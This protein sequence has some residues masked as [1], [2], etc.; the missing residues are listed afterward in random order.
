M[1]LSNYYCRLIPAYAQIAEPL[2][3]LLRKTSKSFQWTT[4][5]ETSFNTL[6]SKLTTSPVLAFPG[7]TDPVLVATDAS[8]T[9]IG[10]VLSQVQD[11][12]EQVIAYW[13]RQ[14]HKAEHNYST[15]ER[16]VLTVV[17]AVK[18]LYPYLYG[19]PFKLITD[20]NP[21]TSLKGIK[22]TGR[23]LTRWLLFLQQFTFTVECKKGTSHSNADTLSRRPPD[24][25]MVAAV[26]TYTFLADP[27]VLIQAQAADLNLLILNSELHRAQPHSPRTLSSRPQKVFFERW[28]PLP[29]VQGVDYTA[30]TY[31][32]SNSRKPQEYSILQEV[33]D[34]LGHFGAKKTFDRVKSRF[35]WPGY[36][37][38]VE[39]WVKQCEQCQKRNP[40]Q[41][42]PIAPLGTIKTT[43]PFERL[44]WDIMG[45]LP[46]STKGNK[47]ILVIT[48]L[49]PNG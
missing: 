33:Y 5:C 18:E 41:P 32:S 12:H 8:D 28:P 20:H 6:K 42:N 2:H 21:L 25:V 4:E 29:R 49:L 30:D 46:T 22:D 1:G 47:Y 39:C 34:H 24:P 31:S 7:F 15:I 43:R 17:G 3:R 40:P 16:E 19:F 26:E 37:K 27:D 13:S 10:G 23:Q 14:L 38:D 35:Y 45:P 11:G 44:S 36:E 48:D 9:A